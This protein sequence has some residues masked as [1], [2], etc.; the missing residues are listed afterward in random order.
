M[1]FPDRINEMAGHRAQ[2]RKYRQEGNSSM[3]RSS[4]LKWVESVRQQSITTGAFKEE[5]EAAK[6]EYREF[7]ETDP[8]YLEIC[9]VVL[10]KIKEQPGILQTDVYKLFPQF[11]RAS[12]SYV[13]YFAA[14]LGKVTR[15][16]KGNTY[17]L[18]VTS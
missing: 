13:L 12:M 16:K 4:Y 5:L 10:P 11:D 15:T 2:A 17:A 1:N 3:A 8:A 14:D 18:A 7:V 9:A 6:K